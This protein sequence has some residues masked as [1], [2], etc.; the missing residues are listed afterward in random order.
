MERSHE[1][2]VGFARRRRYKQISQ[3]LQNGY[4]V[5]DTFD[6]LEILSAEQLPLLI[7]SEAAGRLDEGLRRISEDAREGL[8]AKIKL[9]VTWLPR[10]AYA[11]VALS[12]A[13]N[14]L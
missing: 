3:D 1:S 13:T 7:T 8:D 9:L 11:L 10:C 12:I 14:L 2:L 4:G 5:A 6:H